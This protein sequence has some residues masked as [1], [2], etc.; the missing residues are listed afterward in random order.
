MIGINGMKYIGGP[1]LT[2]IFALTTPLAASAGVTDDAVKLFWKGER[3]A[4]RDML[5]AWLA[6]NPEDID[7]HLLY[8]DSRIALGEAQKVRK[9]YS[10]LAKSDPESRAIRLAQIYLFAQST[11][12][13][14]AYEMFLDD[15]VDFARGWEEFGKYLLNGWKPRM[16]IP[17]LEKALA[18]DPDRPRPHLYIGLAQRALGDLEQETAALRIAYGRMPDDA[19][20]G[21]EMGVTE[22]SNGNAEKAK[23]ILIPVMAEMESDGYAAAVHAQACYRLGQTDDAAAGKELA[24]RRTP[25][26]FDQLVYQGIKARSTDQHNEAVRLFQI[27]IDLNPTHLEAYMQLGIL[28][29]IKKETDEAIAVYT[30]AT[31]IDEGQM[32]QLAWRNLG[33]SYGDKGD[34]VQAEKYVRRSLEVDPDYLIGW[35]DLARLLGKTEQFDGAIETWNRVIGMAPYGWEAKEARETMGYLEKG[36]VPAQVWD[37]LE[38]KQPL[39]AMS[40]EEVEKLREEAAKKKGQ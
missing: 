33:L 36:E 35:V 34:F 5:A 24:L 25:G 15:N 38:F 4:A 2:V 10:D 26:L 40:R 30:K 11:L 17:P 19:S 23:E 28:H 22:L 18:L 14:K 12:K 31:E 3:E 1:I 32:N 7:A 9:D 27:V 20:I 16:A 37:K 39:Q 8:C 13:Q 6:G 29:R 21:L